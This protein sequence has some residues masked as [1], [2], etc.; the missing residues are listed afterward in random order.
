M[1]TK[2]NLNSQNILNKKFETKINGYD[3]NEVDAFLD[4]V[5]EDYLHY[6]NEIKNNLNNLNF[7]T[8][9]INDKEEKIVIL[10]TEKENLLSQIKNISNHEYKNSDLIKR[11]AKLESKKIDK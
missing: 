11:I 10:T 2:I 7:K 3:P 9:I 1:K 8:N 4:K 5:L 6:E